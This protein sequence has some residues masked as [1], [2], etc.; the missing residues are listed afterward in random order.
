[1]P[2]N[3]SFEQAPPVSVPYR[4]FLTAPWFGVAAG[5]LLAWQGADAWASRWSSG[6]LAVAHLLAVGYMLQAMIGAL[7]QFVP[8]ATGGNV[9]RP[10][11]VASIVHPVLV[12]AAATLVVAL[13]A[14]WSSWFFIAGFL[15][16]VG[17][18]IHVAVVGT[19]VWRTTARGPTIG[20]LRAAVAALLVTLALGVALAEGLGRGSAWPLVEMTNVHAAWGLG[21]W[22]FLLLA[23][24]SY[25]VVPM[26]QL[27]PPYPRRL[28]G[29]LPLVMLSALTLWSWQLGGGKPA[30]E[31]AVYFSALAL[32]GAYGATTLWLQARRRRKIADPTLHFF[33]LAMVCLLAIPAS[34][35]LFVVVPDL[36]A[37]PRAAVWIGVLALPGVFVSAIN[38]MLY[39]IVPFLSWLD[40]QRLG[41][42]TT[43]PPNI[44]DMIP[45]S[46][47]AG[48]MRL[49][50]AAL[51]ALLAAVPWPDLTRLAGA[52]FAGSCAWLGWNLFGAARRYR[53]F[54]GR[55]AAAAPRPG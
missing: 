45:E 44:R 30:W 3:L 43:M 33:R 32:A 42:M 26:F 6:A 24:V 12:V 55:I 22:A 28:A 1:L 51:A 18:G 14:G 52:L 4:F 13:V 20:A 35:L 25:H 39:K 54:K 17:V 31:Q 36:A 2:P 50:F 37:H 15:F 29:A 8:V 9:W 11:L 48:Q 10:R 16:V 47:M 23:G 7:F 19:A 46:A 5:L 53:V 34:A 49:H 21:G 38:G 40:L 27:T 41:G